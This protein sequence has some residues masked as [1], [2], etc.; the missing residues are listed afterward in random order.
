[1]RRY[2]L[3][4]VLSMLPV[5]L[6]V[7]FMVF[8]MS[9]MLPG[10]PVLQMIPPEEATQ[11]SPADLARIRT[12][13]GFNRPLL[14]QYADWLSRVLQGDLGRSLRTREPVQKIIGQ[15]LPLT[16]ELAAVGMVISLT[17][18]LPLGIWAAIHRGKLRDTVASVLGLLGLSVPNIFLGIVLIYLLSYKLRLLPSSGFVP[19]SESPLQSLKLM[20]MPGFVVGTALL[21]SVMRI[22]RTSMLE[23]LR[24]E[25]IVTA[26]SKGLAER[27]VIF[28]HALR[29]AFVPVVTVI[30]LQIA[31][32]LGGSFIVEQIFALPGVGKIAVGAIFA[33]DFPVVQGV[34]LFFA[35]LYLFCN[36][37][38]DLVYG[39]IDPRIRYE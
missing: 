36:L 26:R 3:M 15:R 33:R 11:L 35:V 14:V 5:A 9:R 27:V 38:V 17:L 37:G 18:A 20:L 22:T 25:Y 28:R 23:V 13:L 4:R 1:M 12:E 32:L 6:L 19:F 16:I 2:V 10:D 21:G 34:V 30:G 24:S 31:G 29:N 8:M 7:T 39:W